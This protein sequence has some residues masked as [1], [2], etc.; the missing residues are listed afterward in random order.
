MFGVKWMKR[1]SGT[2]SGNGNDWNVCGELG[3]KGEMVAARSTA[4]TELKSMGRAHN[5]LECDQ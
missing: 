1:R 4:Q 5:L 2:S 3:M